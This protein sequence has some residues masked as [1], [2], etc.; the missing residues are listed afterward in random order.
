M[1]A[2]YLFA[3]TAGVGKREVLEAFAGY[4][5]DYAGIP[6]SSRKQHVRV[7][8]VHDFQEFRDAATFLSLHRS[9]QKRVL[10][11]AWQ[12][13]RQKIEAD[14]PMIALVG[15]HVT[16]YRD[17]QIRL[18][19][20]W[21]EIAALDPRAITVLIDDIYHVWQRIEQKNEHNDTYS[22]Y[23]LGELLAWR[24]LEYEE[25][26]SLSE[27]LIP[28]RTIDVWA[29]AVKHYKETL[30]RLLLEPEIPRCY[31]SFPITNIRSDPGARAIIDRMRRRVSEIAT[32]FDPLTIDEMILVAEH[33]RLLEHNDLDGPVVI[34][35]GTRWPV[36][37]VH[38]R[39]AVFPDAVPISIPRSMV[40]ELIGV[41]T[42]PRTPI[43]DHIRSRDFL[44][45]TQAQ[46][47][48]IYRPQYK[49]RLSV[50]ATAE[51]HFS[52]Y[53]APR[54]RLTYWP[55]EDGNK[56]GAFFADF[57]VSYQ[58]EER[59]FSALSTFKP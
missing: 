15:F 17:H 8:D 40:S 24:T 36:D 4:L 33:N 19:H 54:R 37:D 26:T 56:S 58:E 7:Y 16:F 48:A 44:L 14:R 46:F 49:G 30:R 31:L 34:S 1:T 59:W 28:G 39:L 11:G 10:S 12:K 18:V 45:C 43:E 52:T 55:S 53:A 32:A 41:S 27:N 9:E 6:E 38:E 42:R 2:V 50:G 35:Q 47:L 22:H 21:G 3:G 29:F 25:A 57:G 23:T 5:C 20:P 13:L 51:A